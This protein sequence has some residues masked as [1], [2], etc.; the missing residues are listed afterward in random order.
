MFY[1]WI[2]LYLFLIE[3]KLTAINCFL[4]LSNDSG[5]LLNG[6]PDWEN[7]LYPELILRIVYGIY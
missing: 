6:L 4:A 5:L 1:E 2:H 7:T 3:D